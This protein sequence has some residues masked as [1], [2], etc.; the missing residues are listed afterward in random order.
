MGTTKAICSKCTYHRVRPKP[1]LFSLSEMQMSEVLKRENERQHQ[2]EARREKERQDLEQ[3]RPFNYEPYFYPWCDL[4]TPFDQL[5]FEEEDEK[6][7]CDE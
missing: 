2:D 3:G 5:L 4:L 1:Q 6:G 7:A